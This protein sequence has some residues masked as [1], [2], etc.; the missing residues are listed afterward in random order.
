MLHPLQSSAPVPELNFTSACWY[1]FITTSICLTV[2]VALSIRFFPRFPYQKLSLLLV[3]TAKRVIVLLHPLLKCHHS[4][5]LIYLLTIWPPYDSYSDQCFRD[6]KSFRIDTGGDIWRAWYPSARLSLLHPT[7]SVYSKRCRH[8]VK[9]LSC[10]ICP[11]AGWVAYRNYPWDLQSGSSWA[12]RA[13]C[14]L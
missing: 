2:F 1:F 12:K 13:G 5:Q 3:Y 9:P 8:L 6:L 14:C 11:P 10:V 4:L 7:T